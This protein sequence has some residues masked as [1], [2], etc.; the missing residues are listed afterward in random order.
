MFMCDQA[1]EGQ[2]Q[3]ENGVLPFIFEKTI[4]C[5]G[6]LCLTLELKRV[7]NLVIGISCRYGINR[8]QT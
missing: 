2:W 8:S 6:K 4:I 1:V 5:K 3:Y 7:T